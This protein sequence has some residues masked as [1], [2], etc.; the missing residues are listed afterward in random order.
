MVC[1]MLRRGPL[2]TW[3]PRG[4]AALGGGLRE[5]AAAK[6]G[7]LKAGCP[8]VLARQPEAEAAAA[9]RAAAAALGC[10]VRGAAC[11]GQPP[12]PASQGYTFL[13]HRGMGSIVTEA[14]G[15]LCHDKL[16][17]C[18]AAPEH[19]API[20]WYEPGGRAQCHHVLTRHAWVGRRWGFLA[21]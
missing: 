11:A 13:K 15:A 21:A 4:Q 10:T 8:L 5:I 1:V 7:I 6:A 17:G 16:P 12:T 19:K 14:G 2:P 9:L 20:I 3:R 18:A